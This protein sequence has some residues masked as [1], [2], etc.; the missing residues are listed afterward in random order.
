LLGARAVLAVR[1]DRLAAQ[2]NPGP[3]PAG[4]REPDIIFDGIVS[5]KSII[6]LVRIGNI[7]GVGCYLWTAAER[8]ACVGHPMLRV[9]LLHVVG[10]MKKARTR[11]AFSFFTL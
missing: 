9:A 2:I 7:D 6:P 3:V 10:S 11:R 1:A 4:R 5:T 8:V